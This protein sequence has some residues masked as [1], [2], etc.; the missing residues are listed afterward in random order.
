MDEM[1]SITIGENANALT[2]DMY[3]DNYSVNIIERYATDMNF[4]AVSGK[5]MNK[6]L[7]DRR[8]LLVNFE[9]METKQ[10][11]ELF[12]TIK[13]YKNNIPISYMDPEKG[14]ITKRFSCNNLPVATYFI[15][16]DGRKFWTIPT[17]TFSETDES[18]SE[19]DE[20]EGEKWHYEIV[21]GAD[22]YND[23]EISNDISI[24][25]SAGS[26]GWSVGQCSSST[27]S[28]SL[29]FKGTEKPV[30]TNTLVTLYC[31]RYFYGQ[32]TDELEYR[33]FIKS[34]SVENKNIIHF[35]AVD[36]IAFVD[37]S[38]PM[39]G[40]IISHIRAAE[41][42][43]SELSG[44]SVNIAYQTYGIENG[45]IKQTGWTIRTLLNYACV[46]G[47][48]NYY[49]LAN[50]KE[51]GQ[52]RIAFVDSLN[53]VYFSQDEYSPVTIGVYGA[54]IEQ[55]RVSQT[56]MNDPF[57]EEGMTYEDFGIYYLAPTN[58]KSNVLDLVCPWVKEN[59]RQVGGLASKIGQSYGIE[60]NCE[61]IKVN[62]FYPPYTMVKFEGVNPEGNG[63]FYI[64]NA[65]YKLTK[66]GIFA[67][68]SGDTKSLSDFEYVGKTETELKTKVALQMGYQH[69]FIS[70][71]NGI[72]WDDSDVEAVNDG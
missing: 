19:E 39:E 72:Y 68:I 71:E 37:N 17:V 2:V 48:N 9:P 14:Y 56:Q 40:N 55:I 21:I 6:Y 28:G 23:D 34:Y 10:I 31:R 5:S 16:D 27:I 25:I 64:S 13:S 70:A 58:K 24:S 38:Y 65:S 3:L 46:Y 57:L 50:L 52:V 45:D 36:I 33:F 69:G 7:G 43:I 42:V 44:V 66:L 67:S 8:E 62:E 26:N 32:L 41:Q 59:I 1:F 20:D 18:A 47:G 61:S 35:S 51:S 49:A 53:A 29:L 11:N 22:T 4:T 60:F 63:V 15:S 30:K 12:K 54:T